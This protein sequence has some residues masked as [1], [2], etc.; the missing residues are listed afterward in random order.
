MDSNLNKAATAIALGLSALGLAA[1]AW[2]IDHS[3]P[4]YEPYQLAGKRMVFT[5]WYWVRIGQLDWLNDRGESVYASFKD[6]YGP[7]DAH[8]T[9]YDAPR[10]IRIVAEQ[11]GRM[12][13][14]EIPPR[15]PWE[16]GGI[17]KIRFLYDED[18]G[19]YRVWGSCSDNEGKEL[20]CYLEST[21]CKTWTRPKLA[22]V[23]YMGSKDNN[24]IEEVPDGLFFKD[25]IA[26][27]E[28]RYKAVW[29]EDCDLKRWPDY[30]KRRPFSVFATEMDPGRVHSIRAAVSPDSFRW[31]TLPDPI[32]VETSDTAIVAYYDTQLKKYVMYTRNYM[33]GPRAEG[34]PRPDGRW[35]EFVPRR[36]IGRSETDNFREFPLSEVIIETGLDM[37]PT[38]TFYASCRT[39]IP[40]APDHHL[41]FPLIYHQD[42]D[43]FSVEFWTS[44]DGKLWHRVPGS[45]ILNTGIFGQPDGGCISTSPPLVE[46]PDGSWILSWTASNY[47][48]K[49]PRSTWKKAF[50]WLVWPKGRLVALEAQDRG[51]FTTVLV[52][53]E[54]EK[55]KIN[56]VT[57]RAGSILV[58]TAGL[59]GKTIPGRSFADAKPIIGDQ[60]WTPVTWDQHEN[61]GVR[62]GEPVM[63]RFRLDKAKLYGLEFE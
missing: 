28:E 51:Q 33:I 19:K 9:Q 29:D 31:T 2:A 44:W 55:I 37:A 30:K 58:E 52:L 54:G 6:K 5:T 62:K 40:K 21:D 10:G 22:I 35:H 13:P 16:A 39:T 26:P 46:M 60:F 47:P 17:H 57:E 14:F 12:A 4:A 48:H 43:T 11:P 27:P 41:M 25:P 34:V 36:A 56:A 8:F 59:D 63:F 53:A 45:P 32:S 42:R 38:D 23:E 18:M 24:L 15:Y 3:R 61:L 7:W 1:P 20:F 50:G 49:Y